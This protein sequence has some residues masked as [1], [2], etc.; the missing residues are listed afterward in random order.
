MKQYTKPALIDN[1]LISAAPNSLTELAEY[2][3]QTHWQPGDKL[4]LRQPDALEALRRNADAFALHEA[5]RQNKVLP[6][7]RKADAPPAR[8]LSG[9]LEA[10]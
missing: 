3:P 9:G 6:F 2:Q 10:A 1:P 7:N 8:I 5:A 4:P